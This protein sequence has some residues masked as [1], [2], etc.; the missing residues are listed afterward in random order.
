MKFSSSHVGRLADVALTILSILLRCATSLSCPEG[1]IIQSSQSWGFWHLGFPE[2]IRSSP[3]YPYI[4]RGGQ[5][6]RVLMK[7]QIMAVLLVM[8]CPLLLRCP[9]LYIQTE[10]FQSAPAGRH[11]AL[12]VKLNCPVLLKRAMSTCLNREFTHCDI[13]WEDRRG[14]GQKE[15]G[16]IWRRDREES[17]LKLGGND[18]V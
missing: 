18:Q 17:L 9:T 8:F 2:T 5:N 13:Q 10:N 4:S 6:S 7:E 15:K 14:K 3:A 12:Q 16:R 11:C 1:A